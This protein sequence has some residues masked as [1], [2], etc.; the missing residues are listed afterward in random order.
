MILGIDTSA[1]QC[2]VALVGDWV[3]ARS[4]A[5]Q[6]G[7]AEALFPMIE[8]VLAEAGVGYADLTRV[9]VCTGP[10]SFTGIRVGV[11]AARGLALGCGIPAIGITRFEALADPGLMEESI[12]LPG[13]AGTSYVQNF[14][15][16]LATGEPRMADG[17][18]EDRLANPE[19]IARLA[20]DR[21]P[22]L[23][24]APL[25]LRGADAAPPRDAPPV[26]LD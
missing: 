7:H 14:A 16:G 23:P 11:A 10:G 9:G 12:A 24:P 20:A 3:W 6:R 15:R 25:Y 21:V 2:A 19:V 13:R 18:G 17:T 5:M 4:E 22:G 26:M 8:A 1:G